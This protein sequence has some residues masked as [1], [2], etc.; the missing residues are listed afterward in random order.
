[1]REKHTRVFRESRKREGV[2]YFMV[3]TVSFLGPK[4]NPKSVIKAVSFL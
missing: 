1:M 4:Q 3:A 2:L